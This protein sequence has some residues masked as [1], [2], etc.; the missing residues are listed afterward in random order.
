MGVVVK[1]EFFKR[2]LVEKENMEAEFL[3][4]VVKTVRSQESKL[5]KQYGTTAKENK[6]RLPLQI[7]KYIN[8][9]YKALIL[10]NDDYWV[11]KFDSLGR[12]GHNQLSLIEKMYEVIMDFVGR[13]QQ[14]NDE[15]LEDCCH[16]TYMSMIDIQLKIISDFFTEHYLIFD[17]ICEGPDITSLDPNEPL[18]VFKCPHPDCNCST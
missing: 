4:F 18:L 17:H 12:Y 6:A 3:A 16:N 7:I 13:M 8:Y 2:I 14:M 5:Y 10:R 11:E 9:G 15:H 1:I